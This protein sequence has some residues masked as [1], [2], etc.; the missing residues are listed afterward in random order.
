MNSF[1]VTAPLYQDDG[2][3]IEHEWRNLVDREWFDAWFA[4]Q[5]QSG[6]IIYRTTIRRDSL[7]R[8]LTNGGFPNNR[9]RT[10]I[11]LALSIA[12]DSGSCEIYT[13]DLDFY[14]PTEKG[15]KSGRRTRI[16]KASAG[17]VAKLLR[18]ERVYV[19]CVPE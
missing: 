12:G 13:E 2:R 3:I 16:L 14:D 7:E 15:C 9:D 11:R 6:V 4:A 19:R 1:S 10:Y 17:R 5:L 18:R 8:K